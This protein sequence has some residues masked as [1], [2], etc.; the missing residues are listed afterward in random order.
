MERKKIAFA[1]FAAS[2][3]MSNKQAQIQEAML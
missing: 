3:A 1:R 2:D